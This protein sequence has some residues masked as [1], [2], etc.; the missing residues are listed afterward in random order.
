M[1]GMH[2]FALCI[3]HVT[4][5]PAPKALLAW[6]SNCHLSCSRHNAYRLQECWQKSKRMQLL[7]AL[8]SAI[9]QGELFNR[10]WEEGCPPDA[11]CRHC[12]SDAC[13]HACPTST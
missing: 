9:F 11:R 1:R 12:G 13:A 10:D 8:L 7:S 6:R 5:V 4:K 3:L 2:I